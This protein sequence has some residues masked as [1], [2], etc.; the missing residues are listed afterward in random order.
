ML[1]GA[2]AEYYRSGQPA[3]PLPVDVLRGSPRWPFLRREERRVEGRYERAAQPA[4]ECS[5]PVKE[6]AGSELWDLAER[7]R[8]DPLPDRSVGVA[9]VGHGPP[10]TNPGRNVTPSNLEPRRCRRLHRASPHRRFRRVQ[11][12]PI[13]RSS[14]RSQERGR[15]GPS[16]S[17]LDL[18]K[19]VQVGGSEGCLVAPGARRPMGGRETR[20][21]S[22]TV[23]SMG[24]V[25]FR[26][27]QLR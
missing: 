3:S 12:V 26:R 13:G 14:D 24:F 5:S 15:R 6:G 18:P 10:G 9:C 27:N 19:R 21:R 2:T 23:P 11:R 22:P 25:S 4:S 7:P 8:V 1:F 17:I 20:S 16:G